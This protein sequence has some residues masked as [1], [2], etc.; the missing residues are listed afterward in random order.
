MVAKGEGD[1]EGDGDGEVIS[2]VASCNDFFAKLKKIV[3]RG[4]EKR[5]HLVF[6]SWKC[7]GNLDQVNS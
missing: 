7:Y 4:F 5:T 1:G 2:V 3:Q 6:W